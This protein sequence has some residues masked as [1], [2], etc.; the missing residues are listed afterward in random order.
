[1]GLWLLFKWG[2]RENRSWAPDIFSKEKNLN[3]LFATH[4]EKIHRYIDV[5][6]IVAC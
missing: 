2:I 4:C 1:M 6:K 5:N 3:S